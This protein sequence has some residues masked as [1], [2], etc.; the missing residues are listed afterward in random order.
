VFGGYH[1]RKYAAADG[2]TLTAIYDHHRPHAE[3]LA[4]LVGGEP[5]DD[6]AAF[7]AAV[8]V[9][10]IATPG[11]THFPIALASLRAGRHTYVE[12]PLAIADAEA[13]ALVQE[14]KG[15]GLVL[16]CGHQ[17]R[18]VFEAMGLMALGERPVRIEAVRLGTPSDRNRDVSCVPDLMIH[19]LDLGL[20]LAGPGSVHVV[21]AEGG[22]D[23]LACEVDFGGG[24]TGRFEASREAP[25]RKRTM[26]VVYPSGAVEVDFLAPSFINR[27]AHRLDP[28]FAESPDGRDPLGA[29]VGR[30]IAAAVGRGRPAVTGEEG[31]RAL[32][33]AL[34]IEAAL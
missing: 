9:A 13:A 8:D 34:A 26:K 30:F 2:V 32:A 28:D 4:R 11:D 5:F 33:L 15:R 7:L 18:V 22:F 20:A 24:L 17:E 29:S 25:A 27:T 1:A 21:Q 12:K 23:T 16:A 3:A 31:A 14:A 10:T 6:L 19:D